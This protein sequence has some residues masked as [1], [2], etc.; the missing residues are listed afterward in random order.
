MKFAVKCPYCG[1]NYIAEEGTLKCKGCGAQ[2]GLENVVRVIEDAEEIKQRAENRREE[3]MHQQR[4][5]ESNARIENQKFDTRAK[6]LLPIIILV[7][8]VVGFAGCAVVGVITTALSEVQSQKVIEQKKA[9]EEAKW[10]EKEEVKRVLPTITAFVES[11]SNEDF[12]AMMECMYLPEGSYALEKSLEKTMRSSELSALIGR[13]NEVAKIEYLGKN[14]W[15]NSERY[16]L[17][18]DDN[19]YELWLK[20]ANGEWGVMEEDAFFYDYAL[21][22]PSDC[23]VYLNDVELNPITITA[24]EMRESEY[25]VY[26]IPA[27]SKG[28]YTAQIDSAF[29]TYTAAYQPSKDTI[30]QHNGWDPVFKADTMTEWNK[31]ATAFLHDV[32][33]GMMELYMNGADVSAARQYF[34]EDISDERI[35]KCFDAMSTFVNHKY[36]GEM[37]NCQISKEE[38]TA[39]RFTGYDSVTCV[40]YANA[41]AENGSYNEDVMFRSLVG[42][43]FTEN[44]WKI[45]YLEDES[46]FSADLT[47]SDIW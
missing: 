33:T 2:N 35:K 26:T 39:A 31:E 24:H 21:Y 44:G 30:D 42:I 43:K 15:L 16:R 7:V 25:S 8:F 14:G 36:Y 10:D 3:Q 40:I 20:I 28:E 6:Y 1:N 45:C 17:T 19:T 34:T 13:E 5:K 23:T 46:F 9:A 4:I 47:Y 37:Y 11:L 18:V 38:I 29:G 27:I 12:A 22:I 41:K 32:W